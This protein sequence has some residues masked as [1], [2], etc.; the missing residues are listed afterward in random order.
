MANTAQS[1]GKKG[2]PGKPFGLVFAAFRVRLSPV[3]SEVIEP[4]ASFG[5]ARVLRVFGLKMLLIGHHVVYR[6]Q[7]SS[8]NSTEPKIGVFRKIHEND[9]IE[10]GYDPFQSPDVEAITPCMAQV[11]RGIRAGEPTASQQGDGI[12]LRPPF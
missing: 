12:V 7:G 9:F 1:S 3:V 4:P 6:F 10:S 8:Q 5:S 11:Q 2:T